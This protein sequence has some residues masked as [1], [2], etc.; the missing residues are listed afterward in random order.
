MSREQR[1]QEGI[2]AIKTAIL[3]W[4]TNPDSVVYPF[5]QTN[6]AERLFD[7]QPGYCPY[8]CSNCHDDECPC[9]NCPDQGD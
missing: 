9:S 3:E 6:L 5:D 1:R 2:D 7:L 4:A 8:D